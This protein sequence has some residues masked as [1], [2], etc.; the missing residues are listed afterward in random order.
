MDSRKSGPALP[1][2]QSVRGVLGN[3]NRKSSISSAIQLILSTPV[4]SI[5]YDPDFGSHIPSLV[6]EPIDD[7]TMNLLF[8]YAVYDLERNDP[9]INVTSVTIKEDP[10]N[11]RVVLWVGY[12][13]RDDEYQKQQQAPVSISRN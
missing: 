13:D 6:F 10:T 7:T 3:K 1:F 4:G 12:R 5:V 9:R 8:Y 11:R 2:T